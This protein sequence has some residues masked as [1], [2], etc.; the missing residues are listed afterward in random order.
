MSQESPDTG[1]LSVIV[2]VYNEAENLRELLSKLQD[3]LPS[4]A[5]EFEII[6]VNDGSDDGCEEILNEFF[7]DHSF[8]AVI[9]MYK[10]FGKT[11]ALE[12]GFAIARGEII[13][14]LDS[15]L[16]NDP[17]EL[18]SLVA[19]MKEGY[20]LV[21]GMRQGR[22]DARGKILTSRLFNW[23]IRRVTGLRLNDYFSGMRCY[24]R[25]VLMALNLYGDLYRF[26]LVFAHF[27]GFKVTEVPIGH[28]PRL[29]GDS[30]YSKH[31]RMKRG[32]FDLLIVLF[33]IKFNYRRIYL[34]GVWG[35]A[36]TG[37]GLSALFLDYLGRLG[38]GGGGGGLL[39]V[40]GIL[41]FLGIQFLLFKRVSDD[42]V[43]HHQTG[44]LKRG[45]Y[46]KEILR[47][48]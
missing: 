37:L 11:P 16:Q 1:R 42:F 15:D 19:K 14:T 35:V 44:R 26:A 8:V 24:R 10:N 36:L 28:H 25:K 6:F 47:H 12:Q 13:L 18:G 45:K 38:G 5:P 7:R 34:L 27:D 23:L 21:S 40:G 3:V 30:K 31:A 43:C 48:P 33:T 32:L 46:I 20:D 22:K 9:H 4:L 41:V 39:A 2:P 17:A 29:H